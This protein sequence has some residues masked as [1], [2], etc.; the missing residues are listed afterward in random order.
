MIHNKRRRSALR[1]CAALRRRAV[2]R[3]SAALLLAGVA[4]ISSAADPVAT[5]VVQGQKLAVESKIDRK[6][7]TIPQEA[8]G[9]VGSLSDVLGEIPSI[10]VDPDG[11]LSLRGD[12]HV[13]VL[14]DGKPATQLQGSKGGEN[15]QS[16]SAM[17]IERI[18]VLTT[19]PA[20]YKSEGAAGVI[21]II[22]RKRTSA[23]A[24]SGSLQGS[25][26]GGRRS[27]IGAAG[28][29]GTKTLTSSVSA[30]YRTD[31]RQRTTRSNVTGQDPVTNQLLESRDSVNEHT[32]RDTP[33][34]TL[35]SE[36]TPNDRQVLSGSG[37]WTRRGGLRTY[38][39]V[40]DTHLPDGTVI[41][42][43]RRLSSGHDPETDYTATVRFNQKLSR[44][45]ESLD[46]SLHRSITNQRERYD[47]INDSFIPPAATFYDNLTFTQDE[48]ATEA[49][50]DYSLPLTKTQSLKMGYAFEQDDYGFNDTHDFRYRQQVHGLYQSYQG[51]FSAWAILAGLRTEWT[52]TDAALLST[53][54]ATRTSYLRLYPSLHI[55]RILSDQ[56]TL[57]FGASRRVTRPEPGYLNPY[58][59]YEHA[60]SLKSGNVHLQPQFTQSFDLG[61]A[62][63]S[64][65]S[66]YGLTAYYRHN[67]DSVTDVTEYLG[68]NQSLTTKAN[69][70]SDNS[71]GLEFSAA[72]RLAA[73]LSY[74]L[75]GTAFYSQIDGRALG[76]SGLESTTGVNLKAKLDYRPTTRDSAQL[77]FTRTDQRLTAQGSISAIN[78]VN[79]GYKHSFTAALSAVGMVSD[80]F[81]GQRVRRT[82]ST[83]LLSQVYER[84]VEGRVVFI[85][86]T[87][88]FGGSDGKKP[89]QF[90]YD[91][92]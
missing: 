62:Y 51:T 60:P 16:I 4:D 79:I 56:S 44:P 38:T 36:Y 1:L 29:F 31:Y 55:D 78:I 53:G 42:S 40:D 76:A 61:Y 33:S 71:A 67:K 68:G 8:L 65:G 82:V 48:G 25:L 75:S 66:S 17:G 59:D 84:T 10:D 2:L 69:L 28:Q 77:S 45:D 14:I 91:A 23:R 80:L 87:Y 12:S 5:I 88:A 22:T 6:I 43:S 32:R 39:Q 11:I 58:I 57:S 21:N 89:S 70:P 90:E 26:G 86:L 35:S 41:D 50:V 74:S 3:L 20:Q 7:Y 24:A 63:E 27:L 73:R 19:P 46:V 83:P 52:S 64:R 15:L 34:L 49:N 85:G 92:E 37:S 54:T 47:Y 72:G 18:E 81:S 13:L 30:S 9:S